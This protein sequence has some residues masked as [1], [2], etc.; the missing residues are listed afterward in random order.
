MYWRKDDRFRRTSSGHHLDEQHSAN[1]HGI[2]KKSDREELMRIQ[3]RHPDTDAAQSVKA[4]GA[5][6]RR[7]AAYSHRVVSLY[8]DYW[9]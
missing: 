4:N 5:K 1:C 3:I 6:D 9:V 7:S 2:E 8:T